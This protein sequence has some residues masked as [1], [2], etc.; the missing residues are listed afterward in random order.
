MLT[1]PVGERP[2]FELEVNKRRRCEEQC[3]FV[4]LA[5][6]D[7]DF[8]EAFPKCRVGYIGYTKCPQS[9]APKRDKPFSDTETVYHVPY[10]PGTR[11]TVRRLIVGTGIHEDKCYMDRAQHVYEEQ[12]DDMLEWAVDELKE[13]ND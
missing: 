10:I 5:V 3:E 2:F 1:V 9:T 7:L 6:N 13:E 4:S 12:A 11:Y 8:K